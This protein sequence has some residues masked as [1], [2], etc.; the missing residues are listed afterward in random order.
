MDVK[1]VYE[2]RKQGHI[3]DAYETARS[4]YAEDKS[5][6]VANAMFWTAV[7]MLKQ[8][9]GEGCNDEA[10]K[11]YK[12]L[13]RLFNAVN[14]K[15]DCMQDE[16]VR[17]GILLQQGKNR[18]H[19]KKNGPEHLQV[20]IWGEELAIEYLREKGYVILDHDL[21]SGHRDIDII[22]RQGDYIVFMEV[23]TRTNREFVDPLF[24]INHQ[25]LKNLRMAIS[26]YIKSRKINNPWRF[27]VITIVGSMAD[28]N[29][30]INHIED[31]PL[32]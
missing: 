2:L 4:L 22:A 19:Q 3:K 20:G 29:P 15:K 21:R 23:K 12:A 24:A 31:F 30:E 9:V 32:I 18:E 26:H 10:E 7:D 14:E 1:T 25:K 6:Y 27:D 8:K 5:A 13:E 17:C 28:S 11:I 16:L